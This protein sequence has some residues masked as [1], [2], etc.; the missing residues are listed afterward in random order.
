[1]RS[2][3]SVMP[4]SAAQPGVNALK[5]AAAGLFLALLTGCHADAPGGEPEKSFDASTVTTQQVKRVAIATEINFDGIVE[6]VNQSV[7][8]AQ[9][10]GRILELPFDVGDYVAQG[11]VIARFTDTEQRAA[12]SAAQAGLGEARAR[13]TEADLQLKRVSDVY[14]QGLVS[15]SDFN[16]ATAAQKAAAAR[17][18][19]A[20]AALNDAEERLSN[21]VVIAPYSGIVVKRLT[22]IGSA[23]SPGSPLIQGLSLDQLRVQVD[24][25]QQHIGPLRQHKQARILLD[26]G[27]SIEVT[28]LRIPPS[29]DPSTHSFRVLLSLPEGEHAL[30]IFPG[31]LVK[32]AFVNGSEDQLLIPADSV[33]HRGEVTG[34]YV[35]SEDASNLEFRY[36]RTGRELPSAEVVALSGLSAGELIAADPVVAA[37]AY[38]TQN[39]SA[40]K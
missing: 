40:E 20:S 30:P 21:T 19:S 6:A 5:L 31:T 24:I 12:V 37:M 9:V 17:V 29:A 11:D 22:D 28:E 14:K 39:F 35:L 8:S 15:Q 27:E 32:V 25:P 10:S 4:V 2:T 13:F 23:V 18:D 33:A 36:I 26:S 16:Q 1:M 38:K 7:V 34:V 3:K